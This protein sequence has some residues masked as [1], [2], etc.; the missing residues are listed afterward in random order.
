MYTFYKIVLTAFVLVLNGIV[1]INC[2]AL[3]LAVVG[4]VSGVVLMD[5]WFGGDDEQAT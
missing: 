2:H 5:L 4:F 3:V 1:A